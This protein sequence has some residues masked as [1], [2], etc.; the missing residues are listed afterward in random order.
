MGRSAC[1]CSGRDVKIVMYF[2]FIIL[3]ENKDRK[4]EDLIDLSNIPTMII[5]LFFALLCGV[6]YVIGLP[7]GLNYEETGT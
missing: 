6:L 3:Y 1:Q 2:V 4:D 7:F 5:K